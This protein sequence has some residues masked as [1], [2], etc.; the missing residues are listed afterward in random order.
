M[1][2]SN[3]DPALEEKLD[4]S[5]YRGRFGKISR[6]KTQV[7][8][9]NPW[10]VLPAIAVAAVILITFGP[11]GALINPTLQP[12]DLYVR[13]N[14]VVTGRIDAVDA[15]ARTFTVVITKVYKGK[16]APKRVTVAANG[17]MKDF[18]GELVDDKTFAAGKKVVAFVG[19][20]RRRHE[21]DLLVYWGS[22]G[23]GK[24]AAKDKPDRWLWDAEDAQA[25][26]VD[27]DTVPS[28]SGTWNGSTEQLIGLLDDIAGGTAFF[29]RRAYATFKPDV[30]LDKLPKAVRGVA[31][32]DIDRDGRLDVY[33][34]SAAGNR[35]YLQ[36]KP[37]Q[38]VDAT[39]QLKLKGVSSAS[40]SFADV[41]A[42]GRPDLLAGGR[43]LLGGPD[44][45]SPSKLLS[46]DADK[47]VKVAAF[48]E[49]NGDGRPDVVVS[50]TAGGLQAWLN[51]G[52]KGA[53]FANVTKA[54]GLDNARCGAGK[55]G[56]FCPGDWNN[57]TRT[58][59][60][61]AAGDGFLLVQNSKGVFAPVA[62][63]IPFDFTSG[64]D[65][66]P[67]LTGA[68][69]FLSLFGNERLDLIVPIES[70]WHVVA[71]RKGS[72]VD[73]TKYGNEISEGS[74]LHL[75]SVAADLNVD[76][77]VDFYTLSR[78]ANGHNRFLINR[79]YGSF[80]LASVHK[81]A[82]HMFRGPTHQ[83]GGWGAAAGDIDGDGAPDLLIGNRHG[84]IVMILNDTLSLRKTVEHPTEDIKR[85]LGVR[86]LSVRLSGRLGVLGARL[87][88]RD[89]K[90]LCVGRRDIGANIAT[91]CCGPDAVVFAVRRAGKY[92][93]SVRF[94]DGKTVT[95][96]VDLT[97]NQHTSVRVDRSRKKKSD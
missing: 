76:G 50:K 10:F 63:G 87:M 33:A 93:L 47:G 2:S 34:C 44:G 45:F 61:Y 96:S 32:Y 6:M 77:N 64:Q 59:L 88:L 55:T 82:E 17:D 74:Y 58:D 56:F 21:T 54:M 84:Q 18:F 37:L 28:L 20:R 92:A 3:N 13:Y 40:C 22:F 43:I 25:L 35:V 60:F 9:H 91:G 78:S 42:D 31:L 27:N 83:R 51:P 66:E 49:L 62:H 94:S 80:M 38:F 65:A 23:L 12:G 16:F 30:L 4:T 5:E 69:C 41:N 73:I 67:G 36:L 81:S 71:N 89:S 1:C 72:P 7:K 57:D 53:A 52:P 11:A 24:L 46:A 95:R 79:G 15:K 97:R 85:L 29:P 8:P 75:A 39:A 14:A 48:I 86:R 19:K 70:G 68:G 90:G 26:G